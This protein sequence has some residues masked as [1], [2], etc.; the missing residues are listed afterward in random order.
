MSDI[1]E[2]PVTHWAPGSPPARQR[3]AVQALEGGHVL[4]FPHLDFI[5][6]AEEKRA[7]TAAIDESN[8][9]VSF[10]PASGLLRGSTASPADQHVLADMLRRYGNS[11]ISLLD[12]LFPGYGRG[13]QQGRTSFRPVEIEGR[14][15]SWRKD[16]TRL[17]VDSF[18]ATPTQGR[19][20]LRVFTN[21]NPNGQGRH[22]RLGEPFEAVAARFM[23]KLPA[24]L[25]GSATLLEKLGIT[26]TR[27]SAYDHYMLRL[28]D[29]MKADLHYQAEVRQIA[30]EFLPACSWMVYT[31]QASHAAMRGQFALEQTWYLDVAAMDDPAQSPLHVL[32]KIVGRELV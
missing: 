20:I 32:Q 22:W 10:N 15:T 23:P 26:K 5:T 16:D 14:S 18:P 24:P 27:R 7:M 29:G 1:V 3:A 31:D 17:H 25:P 13:R 9:N 8:K 11:T 28:H 12:D 6:S 19:R 30:C 4:L 21:I 2:L